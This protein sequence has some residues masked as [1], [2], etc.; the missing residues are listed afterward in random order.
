MGNTAELRYTKSHEWV[1]PEDGRVLV[2]ITD[3]A[4]RAMGDI[5]FVE[6]P[7]VGA[8]FTAG[9]VLCTV[10]SVKAVSEVYSPLSGKVAEINETLADDPGLLNSDP[11]G[12]WI[13]ALEPA[14]DF[15]PDALMDEGQYEVFCEGAH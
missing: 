2:G 13:A 4:Q 5:V 10:E 12:S 1:K 9:D 15:D 6:F 3:H 7:E 8:A 11:Y 14:G